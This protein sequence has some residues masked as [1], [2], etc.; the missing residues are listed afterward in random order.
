[1]AVTVQ[2]PAWDGAVNVPVASM[3]PG[4]AVQVTDLLLALPVTV[5][6]K[7]WVP[8][9]GRVA[10]PGETVTPTG[11][12]LETVMMAVA[13]LLVSAAAFTVMLYVP[14]FDGAVNSIP[15]PDWARVPPL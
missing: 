7:V 1:V 15:L 12:L 4:E 5:A 9:I 6:A 11:A 3:L 10:D 14:A 8:P 2:R 13:V